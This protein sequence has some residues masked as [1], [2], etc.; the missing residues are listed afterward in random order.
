[1]KRTLLRW[2][3]RLA[4]Y[5]GTARGGVDAPQHLRTGRRGEDD[6]YLYLR[7]LG[8]IVV[9]RNWRSPRQN[10][11][12]DVI[13]WDHDVLCFVEVK[14]RTSR[15]VKPAEAAVDSR[16]Q[17]ELRIMAREYLRRLERRR[18]TRRWL[19][20]KTGANASPET[21]GDVGPGSIAGSSTFPP[22]RF[23]VISV[24]YDG[25]D[26]QVTDITLFRNAFRLS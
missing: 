20:R 11:E 3:M 26:K 8:Y 16:K 23:D 9:G 5:V 14:T 21:L 10:G 24:Y 19:Y 6:A 22:Y 17:R 25:G 7:K 2:L 15:D 4:D 1:M 18:N 13:A 12:V